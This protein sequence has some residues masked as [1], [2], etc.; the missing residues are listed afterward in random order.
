MVSRSLNTIGLFNLSLS[1]KMFAPIVQ[2]VLYQ[3]LTILKT[4]DK[5]PFSEVLDAL[6]AQPGLRSK[7]KSLRIKRQSC[8][9]TGSCAGRS[10]K[11]VWDELGYNSKG[12]E[13][14]AAR[15]APLD[16]KTYASVILSLLPNIV[17]LDIASLLNFYNGSKRF[18]GSVPSPAHHLSGTAWSV[19]PQTACLSKLRELTLA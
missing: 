16:A 12:C 8:Q 11:D 3:S 2:D 4:R 7:I 18:Y 14:W 13:Q 17:K 6:I 9:H 19:A 10:F 15:A 5:V 1:A